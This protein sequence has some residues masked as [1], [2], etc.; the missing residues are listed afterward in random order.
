MRNI[1]RRCF[2]ILK[3]RGWWEMLGMDGFIEIFDHHKL[4]LA[5]IYGDF[6]EYKSFRKIIEVEYERWLHTDEA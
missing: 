2:A 1:L 6:P 4:D 5:G 3:Q